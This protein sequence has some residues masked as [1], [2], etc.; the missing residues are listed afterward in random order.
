MRNKGFTL[1][2]LIMTVVIFAIVG[3]M[4]VALFLQVIRAYNVVTL[5][6]FI[7]SD[8]VFAMERMTKEIRQIK[9]TISIYKA[10]PYEIDFWDAHNNRITFSLSGTS[11]MRNSDVLLSGVTSLIFQ[12]DVASPIVNDLGTQEDEETNIKRVEIEI[13]VESGDEAVYLKSQVHPRN[14]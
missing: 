2:E 13:T 5:R 8:G 9:S 12:Y 10:D 11:L 6:K 7:L 1:I 14:L 4:G 3:G